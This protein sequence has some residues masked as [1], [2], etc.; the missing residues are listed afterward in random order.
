MIDCDVHNGWNSARELLPYL[1]R[2]FRDYLDRGE[3]PG[4]ADSFPHAH[5]P[6]LH[7]EG[8]IRYDTVP[9][10]GGAPGTDYAFMREQ[11]L[12][13][14]DVDYAILLGEESVEVSTLANPYYASALARAYNDWVLDTWA[15]YDERFR[16]SIVIAPQDPHG[17]AA[18]I[19]RL[20]DHPQVVQA[21]VTSGSQRP[22]GDPCYH[23]IWAAA[24]EMGLPIAAHLGGTS[25]VNVNPTGTG[26]PTFYWE[27]HA[28]LCESGMGHVASVL[29]HGIPEK[30][31]G[32]SFVLVEC[33]VAW[34]PAVLWRL[35]ADYQALRKETPWLKRLPSEYARE[36]VR[37]TTQPLERPKNPDALWTALADIG[38]QDMLMFS[39][40]Y[41]HWDFD[42]PYKTRFPDEWRDAVL[43]GNAR[44]L[45]R[46]PVRTEAASANA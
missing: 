2:N 30:Y 12:D 14:Y 13:R 34:L 40:D 8:Y 32:T 5:R 31:P 18:E 22:Y 9:P 46:L 3:L 20:G 6:W 24:S 37:A 4:G 10:D 21:L 45:Y 23:P 44:R 17:A 16:V 28:M 11:L 29:A 26:P 1:D 43:D 38:A 41:P 19:R 7:P 15:R 39:S 42:D 35:D 33:G 27:A 36:F 25:G